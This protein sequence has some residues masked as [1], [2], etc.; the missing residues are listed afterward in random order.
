M[1]PGL[2]NNLDMGRSKSLNFDNTYEFILNIEYLISLLG[3]L[4]RMKTMKPNILAIKT[5][6]KSQLS[7]K[8]QSYTKIS[9]TTCMFKYC[10]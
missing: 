6:N 2:E 1:E 4:L 10:Y 7:L 8:V 5:L 9:L 3:M